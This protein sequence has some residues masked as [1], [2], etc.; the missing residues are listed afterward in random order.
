MFRGNP[1]SRL[2]TLAIRYS[3]TGDLTDALDL[4]EE[5]LRT[6][7]LRPKSIITD[8]EVAKCHMNDLTMTWD[9]DE[10]T[11]LTQNAVFNHDELAEWIFYIKPMAQHLNIESRSRIPAA[12]IAPIQ[13]ARQ[14]GYSY[15]CFSAWL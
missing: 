1:E 5:Y 14:Q 4:A 12:L 7:A 11:W 9:D 13:E 8:M 3:M 2:Q 15:I 10:L 6:H